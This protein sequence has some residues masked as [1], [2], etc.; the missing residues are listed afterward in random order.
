MRTLLLALPLVAAGCAYSPDYAQ[1]YYSRYPGY[2]QGYGYSDTGYYAR[3][4]DG[5]ENCGTPNEP[6][7]CP[8]LPRHP[9]PYYPADRW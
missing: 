5:G 2:A 8:P 7:A 4:Y 9:L 3:P 6:K 1:G